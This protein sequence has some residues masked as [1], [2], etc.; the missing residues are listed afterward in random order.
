MA[1]C[2]FEQVKYSDAVKV[3]EKM[4]K[5]EPYRL[6]GL[7]YFSTCLWHLKRQNDLIYLSNYCLEKSRTAPETC[8]VV[9]NC[10]SLQKEHDTAIKWF[11]QA[12]GADMT[13]AYAYTLAG[14][15]FVANED[16][17]KAKRKF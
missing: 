10:F 6:E 11:N 2:L 9:G 3:Y 7:E 1:R 5:I 13:F 8:C 15:E 17:E 14:H 16:F 12:V 4:L